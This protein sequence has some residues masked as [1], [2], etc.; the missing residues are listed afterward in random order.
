MINILLDKDH[1]N[2]TKKYFINR[3]A[4]GESQRIKLQ[5]TLS[6]RRKKK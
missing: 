2:K 4:C 5:E 6:K 3:K 1:K